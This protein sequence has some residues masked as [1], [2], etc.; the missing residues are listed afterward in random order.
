MAFYSQPSGVRL[1]VSLV[2]NGWS[3]RRKKQNVVAIGSAFDYINS[4][5]GVVDFILI[6][7][8]VVLRYRAIIGVLIIFVVYLCLLSG[9][10]DPSRQTLPDLVV[11]IHGMAPKPAPVSINVVAKWLLSACYLWNQKNL[12]Q[13]I[14]GPTSPAVDLT[15]MEDLNKIAPIWEF[16]FW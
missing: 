5:Y 13:Y 16:C 7:V 10:F 6:G 11:G 2:F 14:H 8:I 12:R 9:Y 15:P 4:F 1:I 3:G